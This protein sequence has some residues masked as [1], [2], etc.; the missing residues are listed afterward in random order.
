VEQA[1]L[2]PGAPPR[3]ETYEA[4]EAVRFIA[5]HPLIGDGLGAALHDPEGPARQAI[6]GCVSSSHRPNGSGPQRA[7]GFP[8]TIERLE[9]ADIAVRAG[10]FEALRYALSWRP[11]WPDAELWVTR[12]RLPLLLRLRWDLLDA[13]YELEAL[14][15]EP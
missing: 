14:E 13:E 6:A 5:L 7:D 1:A 9:E 4:P 3:L 2:D 12:D 11:E 10:Q 8:F 15:R